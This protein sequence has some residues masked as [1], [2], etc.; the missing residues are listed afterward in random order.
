MPARIFQS[1][2]AATG[3]TIIIF[4][5][6]VMPPNNIPSQGLF[7]IPHLDKLVHMVLF[8]GFVWLW[9]GSLKKTKDKQNMSGIL[10]RIFF[11][12]SFYGIFMECFQYFF[13]DRSFDIWDIVADT[14]GAG[15]AWLWLS[16][17]AKK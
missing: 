4:L 17:K 16:Q 5:L 2:W 9:S 13:T 12:S 3:W 8:A 1:K 14:T 11:I 7:G 15:I 10:R 6:M